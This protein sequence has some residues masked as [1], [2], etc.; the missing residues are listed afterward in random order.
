MC[1]SNTS[2]SLSR[3]GILWGMCA[4]ATLLTAFVSNVWV[5]TKEPVKLPNADVTTSISFR[6]GLWRVCPSVKR[7][8]ST[9]HVPSPACSLIKYSG[10]EEIKYSDLGVWTSLE[11]TPSFISRMR[12]KVSEDTKFSVHRQKEE[13]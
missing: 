10:W 5:Y 1:C 12:L 6:I 8:N 9:I 7:V 2:K 3:L 11:F 13:S 4:L